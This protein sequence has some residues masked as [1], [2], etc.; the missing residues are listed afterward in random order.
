VDVC[1]S[2]SHDFRGFLFHLAEAVR[3]AR[4]LSSAHAR[5]ICCRLR[6]RA[7]PVGGWP[8]LLASAPGWAWPGGCRRAIGN[9]RQAYS[10]RH[11]FS[12]RLPFPVRGTPHDVMREDAKA[13]MWKLKLTH[14]QIPVM[15]PRRNHPSLLKNP[16]PNH[17]EFVT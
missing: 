14:Y 11:R 13:S 7:L 1:L 5:G 4:S 17:A 9:I 3:T 2:D 12:L 6:Q 10:R 8:R 16:R 15:E